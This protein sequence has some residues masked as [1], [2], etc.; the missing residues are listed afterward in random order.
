MTSLVCPLL[1]ALVSVS[2]P[3]SMAAT[4][5]PTE[6]SNKTVRQAQDSANGSMTNA[7]L[8]GHLDQDTSQLDVG[9]T[10]GTTQGAII[11]H[12]ATAKPKKNLKKKPRATHPDATPAS[13]AK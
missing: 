11:D 9:T 4:P 8:T 7:D 6:P 13:D 2:T 5:P 12:T 3:A 1:A 10:S